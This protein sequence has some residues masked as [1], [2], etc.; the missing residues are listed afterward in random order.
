MPTPL[1]DDK[2][3]KLEDK[4]EEELKENHIK[5]TGY[6]VHVFQKPH[7][8]AWVLQGYSIQNSDIVKK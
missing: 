1:L 7:P 6:Q 5:T 4:H 8:V 3:E 2:L